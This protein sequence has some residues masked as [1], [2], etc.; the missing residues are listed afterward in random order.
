MAQ[1]VKY[2]AF[3]SYK[4]CE[5]DRE[6]VARLHKKLEGFR[7]PRAV[8]KKVGK[9]RLRRVFR[10]EAELAV[11]EDLSDEIEKALSNSRYLICICSPEYLQ[12]EWCMKEIETFLRYSDKKHI[13]LVLANGEP[14]NAFPD[15]LCYEEFEQSDDAGNLVKYRRPHEPLAADCR[16][17][18]AKER[19]AAVDRAVPRLVAAIL[20]VGYD[21]LLQRQRKEKASRRTRRVL[22]VFG[23][24][25]VIIGICIFFLVKI[26]K[27][28]ALIRQRYA[29]TL[30]VTSTN[31]LKDGYVKDAVYAARLALAQTDKN[32]YSDNAT[33]ALARALGIYNSPNDLT[34]DKDIKLPCSVA[35]YSVSSEGGYLSVRGTDGVRYVLNTETGELVYSFAEDDLNMLEFDGER[36]F[37]FKQVA[38][39]FKYYSLETDTITDLGYNEVACYS[40]RR[41]GG[42]VIKC[43]EWM[44]FYRGTKEIALFNVT[45]YIPGISDRNTYYMEFVAGG[46]MAMIYVQD[47]EVTQRYVFQVDLSNGYISRVPL[48]FGGIDSGMTSDGTNI[49]WIDL[50]EDSTIIWSQAID[51]IYDKKEI[52]IDRP[53]YYLAV[54]GGDVVAWGDGVVQL[55]SNLEIIRNIEAT[56]WITLG[57]VT[58]EGIALMEDGENIH[59]FKDGLYTKYVIEGSAKKSKDVSNGVI[60][61]GGIGDNHIATYTKK[62][63]EYLLNYYGEYDEVPFLS[64]DDPRRDEIL[65]LVAK[66]NPELDEARFNEVALCYNDELCV[67]QCWDGRTDVYNTVNGERV[68]TFYTIDGYVE[69]FYHDKEAGLYYIGA[70]NLEVFDENWKNVYRIPDCFL[71][72][73][74]R[75]TKQPVVQKYFGEEAT[76]YL[77]YPVTYELLI[78]LADKELEGYTPDERVKERYSLE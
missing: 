4:H 31:L 11:A 23:V 68:K 44:R 46:S 7:I 61:V 62:K 22:I 69:K 42:Y 3:I 52:R 21:D 19:A 9:K 13:L 14:N 71:L 20:G 34:A 72:G 16:G 28:N 64:Y 63:S 40:D 74:D 55:N 10:D 17:E 25:G 24:L 30:A 70:S 1:R 51:S 75:G 6:I 66:T 48:A 45:E 53:M 47:F 77:A 58:D 49:Y 41:G 76:N 60:Y 27:Q 12:S 2:D 29:D 35:F 5:P 54:D 43:N 38:E 36:G 78:K 8:A 56:D 50:R 26:S 67:I 59:V 37:V 15:V 65:S 33:Q 39:N 32:N 57:T 73:I 18:N